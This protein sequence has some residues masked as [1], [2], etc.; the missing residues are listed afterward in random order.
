MATTKQPYGHGTFRA[1]LANHEYGS[2]EA[3]KEAT[4]LATEY[5]GKAGIEI[6]GGVS[7]AISAMK[8]EVHST[9]KAFLKTHPEGSNVEL[10]EPEKKVLDKAM[11]DMNSLISLNDKI[12]APE[13]KIPTP[14]EA[15]Q[16]LVQ[17]ITG[18]QP[19]AKPSFGPTVESAPASKVAAAPTPEPKPVEPPKA[20][21]VA[22]S[23]GV[24]VAPV[25]LVTLDE[26]GLVKK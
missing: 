22:K 25:H 9:L 17:S 7:N 4:K 26:L 10:T 21:P 6:H 1:N 23:G 13:I 18:R 15:N 5:Y 12:K 14:M 20:P 19:A 8:K 3:F 24:T 16:A 11:K 2:T